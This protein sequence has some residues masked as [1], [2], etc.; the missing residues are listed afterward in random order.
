MNR[1]LAPY[2]LTVQC[3]RDRMRLEDFYLGGR[4]AVVVEIGYEARRTA[5]EELLRNGLVILDDSRLCLGKLNEVPWLSSLLQD[6]HPTAWAIVDIFPRKFWKYDPEND[7]SGEIG[8]RGEMFV[9]EEL[10]RLLPPESHSD[11][12]HISRF[13]D[14][15]GFDI[16]A[17]S[18][19]QPDLQIFLEVKATTRPG[20]E[21]VFH[22]SRNEYE[23]AR[24]S[25]N[26][27]LVLVCLSTSGSTIFGHLEGNSL[28]NYFPLDS[29]PSFNWT[30]ARGFY[31]QDDLRVGLP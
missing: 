18:V 25:T 9:I 29:T 28:L 15:A 1:D 4:L 26:W 12:H 14:L 31:T 24:R 5:L 21:F 8:F 23:T 16:S 3:A 19:K 17:P 11:I 6:G 13:D 7:Q 2:L 20:P 30:S 22:L 27:F 10:Q